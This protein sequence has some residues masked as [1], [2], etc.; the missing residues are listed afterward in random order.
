MFSKVSAS[1]LNGGKDV[2]KKLIVEK[3]Y[4]REATGTKDEVQP[5]CVLKSFCV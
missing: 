4:Y 3:V 1:E 2:S 5:E